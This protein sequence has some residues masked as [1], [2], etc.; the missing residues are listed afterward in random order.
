MVGQLVGATYAIC[1]E[2]ALDSCISLRLQISPT[3][4]RVCDFV[5]LE[6]DAPRE[7]V[8]TVPPL[9]CVEVLSPDQTAPDEIDTLDDY[10]TMGVPNIWL[11]DPLRRAAFTFDATGL[12]E[13]DPTHLTVPSTPNHHDLTEAFAAID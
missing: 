4:I 2:F 10:L 1:K 9:L 11:I 8:P 12:H 3:R 6:P 7:Q 13:A 5:I